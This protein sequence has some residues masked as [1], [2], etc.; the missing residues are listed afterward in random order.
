MSFLSDPD[1]AAVRWSKTLFW[2]GDRRL[3]MVCMQTPGE[4]PAT[5]PQAE[6]VSAVVLLPEL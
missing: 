4:A 3:H 2:S 5:F 6:D 1:D